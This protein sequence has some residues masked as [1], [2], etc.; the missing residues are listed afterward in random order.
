MSYDGEQTV[1]DKIDDLKK[2]LLKPQELKSLSEGSNIVIL[3]I[4]PQQES[5]AL[6]LIQK[7]F[8]NSSL[9]N[10]S[11]I[12]L[13]SINQYGIQN[14]HDDFEFSANLFL[15]DFAHFLFEK[16]K[17]TIIKGSLD[18]YLPF[19]YRVGLLNEIIRVNSLVESLAGCLHN[20]FIILYPGKKRD[21]TLT[22]L[23]GRH[24]TS[25]YRAYII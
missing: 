4:E 16:L 6:Q 17:N 1:E 15:Q 25:V 13:D 22:Y 23:N 12:L 9:I 11:K 20:P 10:C 8:P 3:V 7:K 2:V 24:K 19:L 14:L 18:S 5:F 21:H